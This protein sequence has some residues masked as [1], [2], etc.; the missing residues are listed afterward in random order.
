MHDDAKERAQSTAASSLYSL[1]PSSPLPL[2]PTVQRLQPG[3]CRA[4]AGLCEEHQVKLSWCCSA[5]LEHGQVGL[6]LADVGQT[7]LDPILETVGCVV[8]VE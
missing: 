7:Q 4:A 1:L 2:P 8:G 5:D 3:C 6:G